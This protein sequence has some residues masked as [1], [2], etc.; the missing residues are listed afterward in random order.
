MT[1]Q[2]RRVVTA[3]DS[4]G[5][6]VVKSDELATHMISNRPGHQSLVVWTTNATPADNSRDEDGPNW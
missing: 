5:K 2:V 3:H 4:D 1:L 6:A